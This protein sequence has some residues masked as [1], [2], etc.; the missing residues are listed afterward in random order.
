MKASG[1]K[2]YTAGWLLL[3]AGAALFATKSLGFE[4]NVSTGD[5][6]Q[7]FMLGLG[8]L[9]IRHK[10]AKIASELEEFE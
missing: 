10:Q 4:P 7:M 5:M 8:V 2:G 6:Y 1:W 3:I 9:G